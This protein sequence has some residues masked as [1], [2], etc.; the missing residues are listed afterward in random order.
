[1]ANKPLQSIQFPGLPDKYTV[2][3]MDSNFDGV[4][5][6]VP[7][8]SKV[9]ADI[10]S[11]REDLNHVKIDHNSITNA[12]FV[13]GWYD[14]KAIGNNI[15]TMSESSSALCAVI[16]VNEGDYVYVNIGGGGTGTNAGNAGARAYAFL[17]E[18]DY[19]IARSDI[20]ALLI[21]TY[22]IAPK[23]AVKVV[24]QNLLSK[25]ANGY[26]AYVDKNA[27]DPRNQIGRLS[28]GTNIL[29]DY[30]RGYYSNTN[31]NPN[32][33]TCNA[34]ENPVFTS[35]IECEAGELY[36]IQGNSNVNNTSYADFVVFAGDG[37]VLLTDGANHV[38]NRVIRIP[39]GA[40]Y[41]AVHTG[42]GDSF[43]AKI[44]DV[45]ANKYTKT[46][47]KL[48]SGGFSDPTGVKVTNNKRIRTS[49]RLAVYRNKSIEVRLPEGYIGVLYTFDENLGYLGIHGTWDHVFD[50]SSLPQSVAFVNILIKSENTSN[51][52]ISGNVSIVQD[53]IAVQYSIDTA[54][55]ADSVQDIVTQI[56]Y[57][58]STVSKGRAIDSY[59]DET[60]DSSYKVT[61]YVAIPYKYTKHLLYTH[62]FSE[63]GYAPIVAFYDVNKNYVSQD[64]S[65]GYIQTPDDCVYVKAVFPKNDSKCMIAFTNET[66]RPDYAP[67]KKYLLYDNDLNSYDKNV[68]SDGA[69]TNIIN[70]GLMYIGDEQF[71]YGT[72][73]TA[74]G[75]ECIK[76]TR[77]THTAS[78]A[79]DDERYQM[80]CS[81]FVLLMM[82]GIVPEC[83]RY[84]YTKNV[85]SQWGYRFNRLVEYEGYVYGVAQTRDTKRLYA[86]SIAEYAYKNG[87]LFLVDNDM[88][89]LRA[90]DIFFLSNQNSSYAFFENIGHCGM[91]INT[92]PMEDGS[93]SIV[94]FESNGGNTAPCRVHTYSTK[95]NAMIYAARFPMPHV[96][97]KAKQIAEFS[98]TVT[99][100]LSGN[101]GDVI[102]IASVQ[103][104]D[105]LTAGRVYTVNA[106]CKL[107]SNC[108]LQIKANGMTH[109]GVSNANVV[110]RPD[111]RVILRIFGK[112]GDTIANADTITLQA[113]CTDAVSGS[114]VLSEFSVYD[115]YVS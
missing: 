115:G 4:S 7:D 57:I 101:S 61:D 32:F 81:T 63:N 86:N 6:K 68:I 111:G 58:P 91:V 103:L 96:S 78:S 2:P 28:D 66:V 22:L 114:A 46:A 67:P 9:K 99:T 16:D 21:N 102:D 34:S 24:V 27:F 87:Y 3:Q 79:Y 53:G 59:G 25:V 92:I 112:A 20:N 76:T 54:S 98:T 44:D 45:N 89:N 15:G 50:L 100:A 49:R 64:V 104:S 38:Y 5:G 90:G 52:D 31:N 75:E 106:K 56:N 83:S 14:I 110:N 72:E 80:D 8:S 40:T 29:C 107:P 10:S 12:N 30:Q 11:L 36:Y 47:I 41:L 55:I 95:N 69:V 51:A 108:H 13:F 48:E 42:S 77:D 82:M 26:Y 97:D 43:V 1:M 71:G 74:F 19:I 23:N 84:F 60:F 18:D 113:K 93:Q 85:P 105:A 17:D 65:A 88:G 37:T 94:T 73:H 109:L 35:L 62:A 39:T 33:P 70:T